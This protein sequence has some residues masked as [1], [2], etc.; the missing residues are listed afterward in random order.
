[1]KKRRYTL[2]IYIYMY[3]YIYIYISFLNLLNYNTTKH[4]LKLI[5]NNRYILKHYAVF[6]S[7]NN[8]WKMFL[9]IWHSARRNSTKMWKNDTNTYKYKIFWNL[10][11]E[12]IRSVDQYYDYVIKIFSVSKNYQNIRVCISNKNYVLISRRIGNYNTVQIICTK[13]DIKRYWI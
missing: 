10:L 3:I 12:K 1:M 7:N 13:C 8:I 9:K 5:F 2:Y 11:F 4:S 6:E